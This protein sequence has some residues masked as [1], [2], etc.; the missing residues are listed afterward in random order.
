MKTNKYITLALAISLT[1][2]AGAGCSNGG[3]D[4][5]SLLLLAGARGPMLSSDTSLTPGIGQIQG[6]AIINIP[7]GTALNDFKSSIIPA[8]GAVFDVYENDGVT[9]A[10]TLDETCVLMITAE[11]GTRAAYTLD[12]LPD[13]AIVDE[14]IG[15][16]PSSTDY[17]I[18]NATG[19]EGYEGNTS[20]LEF[21]GD[22]AT[23]DYL[24]VPDADTLT[25]RDSGTVEV[26]IKGDSFPT[27]AGIVHKGEQGDF[28]DEAW[29][30]QIYPHEGSQARLLMLITGDDGNW[31]GVHGS[32][33]LQPG[34]WYHI[35]GTWDGL[36]VRLYVN[37]VL[38]GQ[39]DNTTG[40]VR[41]SA[42]SL[43]IGGQLSE[44]YNASYGNLGWD[45]IIDRVGIRSDSLNDQQVLDRYNSL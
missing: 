21:D 32:F 18:V 6:N 35:V 10:A 39:I 17:T 23:L 43:I 41:D 2:F 30:L 31:I 11:N 33:D 15:F 16:D 38:D 9:P 45:G 44:S 3:S 42:G 36:T 1:L 24:T 13:P 7:F 20:A 40:G 5:S 28:S 12:I 27:C 25:L 22:P 8:E 34:V 14:W 37:G 26:L 4:T 19:A 29:S